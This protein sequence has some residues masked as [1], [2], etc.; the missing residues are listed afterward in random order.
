MKI[1]IDLTEAEYKQLITSLNNDWL[2]NEPRN[3]RII[4][5][6]LNKIQGA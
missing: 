5:S 2:E 6:L 4:D 1:V 3:K